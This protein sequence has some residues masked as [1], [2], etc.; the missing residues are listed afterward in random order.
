MESAMVLTWESTPLAR[1][2]TSTCASTCCGGTTNADRQPYN[3]SVASAS[4]VDQSKNWNFITLIRRKNPSTSATHGPFPSHD[5]MPK[6]RSAKS[7]VIRVIEN[8]IVLITR[9]GLCIGIGVVVA[10][11]HV[12]PR[13][14]YT[15]ESTERRESRTCEQW[16]RCH[17]SGSIRASPKFY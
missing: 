5:G 2:T 9:M 1:N 15:T 10:V 4:S 6:S 17:C 8:I 12:R 13:C 16:C 7:C 14:P 11:G 3:T